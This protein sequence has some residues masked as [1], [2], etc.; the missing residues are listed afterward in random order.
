[1]RRPCVA[2][3]AHPELISRRND[4]CKNKNTKYEI[5]TTHACAKKNEIKIRLYAWWTGIIT[6]YYY[7]YYYPKSIYLGNLLPSKDARKIK[8]W[9]YCLLCQTSRFE[10]RFKK[11]FGSEIAVFPLDPAA[12]KMIRYE[13]FYA[14]LL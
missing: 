14:F 5:D 3:S 13:R 10:I 1:M 6:R 11:L 8:F 2:F 7:C 12:L 9:F 4:D